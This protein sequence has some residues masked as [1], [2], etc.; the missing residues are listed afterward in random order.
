MAMEAKKEYTNKEL[1]DFADWAEHM[2]SVTPVQEWKKAYGAIRQG[3][4]WLLRRR[5]KATAEE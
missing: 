1:A 4:D 3:V 5:V 2:E